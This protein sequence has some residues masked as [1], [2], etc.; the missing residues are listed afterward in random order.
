[1]MLLIGNVAFYATPQS[2]AWR[3][4]NNLERS[5]MLTRMGRGPWAMT[6]WQAPRCAAA[7]HLLLLVIALITEFAFRSN[8]QEHKTKTEKQSPLPLQMA[9]CFAGHRILCQRMAFGRPVS[10]ELRLVCAALVSVSDQS[11]VPVV[12]RASWLGFRAPRILLALSLL[13]SVL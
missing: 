12:F 2:S 10:E 7:K 13:L 8:K 9:A 4:E 6:P 3:K 11:A 5:C 1:M